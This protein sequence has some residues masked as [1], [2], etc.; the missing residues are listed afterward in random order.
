MKVADAGNDGVTV[1]V[2]APLIGHYK[3]FYAGY[4]EGEFE[5][6]WCVW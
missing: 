5:I 4:G 2:Y 6:Q 3:T 1:K